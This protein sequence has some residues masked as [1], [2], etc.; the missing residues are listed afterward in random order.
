M[1]IEKLSKKNRANYEALKPKGFHLSST[2]NFNLLNA[3]WNNDL[4]DL[5]KLKEINYFSINYLGLEFQDDSVLPAIPRVELYMNFDKKISGKSLVRNL[6]KNKYIHF[7][8]EESK[9]FFKV[10]DEMLKVTQIDTNRLL[11]STLMENFQ[12]VHSNMNPFIFGDPK[13]LVKVTNAGWKSV[14]FELIPLYKASRIFLEKASQI[15]TVNSGK[16]LQVTTILFDN[17][18]DISHELLKFSVSL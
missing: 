3:K 2:L 6:L 4:F 10:G 16:K 11:I 1:V 18:I 8:Y 13:Y 12:L 15:K 9:D 5:L 14:L 17:E 7:E